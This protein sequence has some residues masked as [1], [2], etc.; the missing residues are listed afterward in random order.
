LSMRAIWEDS[1]GTAHKIVAP[2]SLVVSAFAPVEDTRRAV[3][4]DLKKEPDTR[5]LLVDLGRGQNRLGGS[6]LAQTHNQLGDHIPDIAPGDL[7]HFYNAI[8]DLLSQS[9]ILAY[10]DRSDG[11]LFTTVAEM[12]FAG[13]TG[14]DLDLNGLGDDAL[15]ALF[16]EEIGAVI[17]YRTGD[18]ETVL[19]AFAQQQIGELAHIIG[20]PSNDLR[21]RITSHREMLYTASIL[22]LHATWSELTYRMQAHRDNPD[23]A[24]EEYE[25][26]ADE[27][28]PGLNFH[29]TYETA[30]SVITRTRPRI[31]ALREQGVN[32]Q[33]EMAA[34]F[35]AAGF[36]SVDVTMTDLIEERTDL[37]QFH[38]LVACGGFSYGD[39]LGAGAGWA[40]SVLFH[41]KLRD[42]FTAFFERPETFSLGVCNGCQMLS[43]LK[44]LIPGAENWPKFLR[45]RSEQFEARLV[46]VEV[47][48]SNSVFLKGM[49]GS[50]LPIAVAHGE[51]RVEFTEDQDLHT[52][53]AQNQLCLRYV[54]NSGALAD[55][56][57]LNPNGSPEGLTAL[58]SADGRATIMM[59]HPER[60]FRNVQL[61]WRPTAWAG[62]EGPW[63]KLF[64]NARAFAD[65][66]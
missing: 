47:L 35:D 60:V 17:Q 32:G 9:L 44:E 7:R 29:R 37:G 62:E 31:A 55:R 59:P 13:R 56:Y 14:V 51:G 34:A 27:Q 30:P 2:L 36:E 11:G 22:D 65:G 21:L 40:R 61:S 46:T 23:C 54:D 10:H 58:S 8:Q 33:V 43:H 6:C 15:A 39:V 1:Q 38:G 53:R 48:E 45:N 41:G 18:E 16:S 4:P 5:L 57:P 19:A 52:A 49:A 12:A 26:I 63:L 66:N 64:Q 42:Q 50:R 24:R 28:D 20:A 3:T 25:A